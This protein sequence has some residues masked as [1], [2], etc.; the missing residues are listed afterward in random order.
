MYQPDRAVRLLQGISC[1]T[2]KHKKRNLCVFSELGVF[3]I[4]PAFGTHP[5]HQQS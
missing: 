5:A 2:D 4:V 1:G 3:G